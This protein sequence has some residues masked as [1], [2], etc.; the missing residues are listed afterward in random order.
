MKM[1]NMLIGGMSL[2]L[3]ACISIGGTLA[4]L[5]DKTTKVENTFV[6]DTAIDINLKEAEVD[7]ETG[8]AVKPENRREVG[9]SYV[10][11]YPGKVVDKDPTVTVTSAPDDGAYVYMSLNGV[12]K[13][14]MKLKYIDAAG[15][16][17]DGIDN[18]KWQKVT[19]EEGVNGI[20]KYIGTEENDNYKA[21]NGKIVLKTKDGM[22]QNAELPA[23]FDKVEFIYANGT[24]PTINA[25]QLYAYSVQATLSTTETKTHNVMA[26]EVLNPVNDDIWAQPQ[27]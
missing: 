3:V 16:V 21:E 13:D 14:Q 10:S 26:W 6:A 18:T 9:N 5:T 11:I 22:L 4:Y 2:A 17:K 8:L 27:A 1:K 20:Y 19:S 25:V 7:P 15:Q 23:L 12:N 24:T